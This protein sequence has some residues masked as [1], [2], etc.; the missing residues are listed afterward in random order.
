MGCDIHL[1]IEVKVKG[2]WE[3][4]SMSR[5]DRNYELFAKLA[6]V[7]NNDGIEPISKPRGLP[8]GISVLTALDAAHWGS[9]GHNYSYITAEEIAQLEDWANQDRQWKGNNGAGWWMEDYFGFFFGNTFAGW[10]KYPRDN[11]QLREL[12]VE[13]VRFVFWFDN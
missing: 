8:D 12:G 11:E 9:D 2:K 13:D 3:H 7:R 10:Y 1:H 5:P 4:Y 6:N